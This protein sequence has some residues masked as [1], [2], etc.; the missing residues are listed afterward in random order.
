[1]YSQEA[2]ART[3]TYSTVDDLPS[4]PSIEFVEID[5]LGPFP[6]TSRGN[7]F[8]LCMTDSFSKMSFPVPLP[9]Q[10]TSLVAQTLV[11]L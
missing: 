10:T 3:Q 9:D 5:V 1:M 11:D 7:R 6:T 4:D 2:E 8:L